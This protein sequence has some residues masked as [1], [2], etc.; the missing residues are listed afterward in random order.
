MVVNACIIGDLHLGG[1]HCDYEGLLAFIGAL[2][3]R[4][5][6]VLNGDV[7][8]RYARALDVGPTA[9]VLDR[10][11][12]ESR[13]RRVLWLCGNH[14]RRRSADTGAIVFDTQLSIDRRLLVFHGNAYG[15]VLFLARPL[16]AFLR[17]A[18]AVR[19]RLWEQPLDV[20]AYAKRHWMLLYQIVRHDVRSK[21]LRRARAMGFSAVVCG[22]SHYPE[23][24]VVEGIRYLNPGA[25]T[26]R[27][28]YA[29]WVNDET[30]EY[31]PCASCSVISHQ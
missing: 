3:E 18:Y 6:L 27:P 17:A 7:L 21:A 25:W 13:R 1:R 24:A 5:D 2:P 29:V 19:Y 12:A 14:D 11:R 23:D 30:I 16:T 4:C 28:V 26:E 22:H 10:L 15:S 20:A 8:D 31:R 9:A